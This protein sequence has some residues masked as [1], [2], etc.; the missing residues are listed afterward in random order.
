MPA[1]DGKVEPLP[2]LTLDR[3]DERLGKALN[4]LASLK[5]GPAGLVPPETPSDD[6]L[7][8]ESLAPRP[9]LEPQ[10]LELP[11]P[12]RVAIAPPP[13]RPEAASSDAPALH[14]FPVLELAERLRPMLQAVVWNA[15]TSQPPAPAVAPRR[16]MVLLIAGATALIA[17]MVFG[18]LGGAWWSRRAEKADGAAVQAATIAPRASGENSTPEAALRGRIS[19]KDRDGKRLP[20][21][22][23]ML[24]VLPA[25]RLGEVKL[26]AVGFRPGDGPV[27]RAVSAAG[28]AALGGGVAFAND[29]GEYSLTLA[30]NGD[31]SVVVL[32]HFASR[33]KD[34]P[35]DPAAD[36]LVKQFLDATTSFWGRRQTH[37]D[38]FHFDGHTPVVLDHLFEGGP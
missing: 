4:E 32:S 29:E 25:S 18:S 3:A 19:Y 35:P 37:L 7:D 34:G 30:A 21:A 10:P 15:V 36:R 13:P 2:A 26:S 38:S 24:L 14:D 33:E 6:A 1:L 20:D 31:Y 5:D 27:D 12:E 8:A 11:L 23:A 16:D 9:I 22:G 28:M 17:G